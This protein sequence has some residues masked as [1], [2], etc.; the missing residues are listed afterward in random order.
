MKEVDFKAYLSS[1]GL[2]SVEIDQNV[3]FINSI[4][5]HLNQQ[6]GKLTIEDLNASSLQSV[7]DDLIDSSGNTFENFIILLRYAKATANNV[8]YTSIFEHMD[9]H[10]AMQNLSQQLGNYVGDELRDTVFEDLPLPPLGTSKREK[11]RYTYRVMSRMEEI[12]G[13]KHCRDILSDSLRDL[14]EEYYSQEKTD[15]YDTCEGDL[16]RYLALKGQKFIDTLLDHQRDGELFFGQEIT[17]DVIAFVKQNPEIGGGV[18]EGHVIYETKVPYN[19]KAFLEATDPEA[20]RYHYCHCP[21]VKESLRP[22]SLK[23]S[24]TFCQCSAGFHKKPYEV[25]FD[26][27]LKAKV[28]QSVLMSDDRCRFAIY[29]PEQMEK[30][31]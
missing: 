11:A 23:V 31:V 21:W 5:A 24:A 2:N 30:V 16:D 27:S 1:K 3:E 18:R 4:E 9:G 28:M 7:V 25:I 19:T 14:P 12:F 22:G 10:E 8:I 29:L 13:E 20:K 17:E 26:T 6:V 15:F